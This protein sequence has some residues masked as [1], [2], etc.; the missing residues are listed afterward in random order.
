MDLSWN[1]VY[2]SEIMVAGDIVL[3]GADGNKG[4]IN[5]KDWNIFVVSQEIYY[6]KKITYSGTCDRLL[7]EY[8]HKKS[9]KIVNLWH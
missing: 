5:D 4:I 7:R 1:N 6:I 2:T 3:I 9:S 8:F